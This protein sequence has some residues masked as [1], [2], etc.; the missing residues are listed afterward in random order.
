M[1]VLMVTDFYWPHVGGVEQHVRTLATALAGRGHEVTVATIRTGDLP[2]ED[3]DGAVEVL[4]I[5]TTTQR[6]PGLHRQVRP[7]APPIADPAAALAL[8][9]L[10]RALQPDVIHGHDWLAR[11]LLPLPSDFPPMVTSLHYYTLS[12]PR[13]DLMRDGASCSGPG[14]ARCLRC[15]SRHYGIVT[16][17]ATAMA[18]KLGARLERRASRCFLSVSAATAAGNQLGPDVAQRIVP[19]LLPAVHDTGEESVDVAEWLELL[20]DEQYF[21]YVGDQRPTKGFD[22]L[23]AAY[24]S[25]ATRRPLVVIGERWAESPSVLP[26]GAV[27]LGAWPNHAVRA[28]YR[29]ARA[30]IVPSVWAEPFGIVAIESMAAGTPVI[31]SATGGLLDIVDH[32][33]DGLLVAP[34]SATELAEAMHRLDDDDALR[35]SLAAVAMVSAG[36]YSA[37]YVVPEIEEIYA[38]V[39]AARERGAA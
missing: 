9:R 39:V 7:W 13:K 4:R 34:G 20:P 3:L 35:D 23:L 28:A 16:G 22:V 30:T 18:A 10:V 12:C 25:L 6:L 2:P 36:R 1:R 24:A 31:A 5:R 14:P 27:A 8:R 32:G 26:E 29:R 33:V 17:P 15:A 38:S 19:N 21:L 11:S 37:E